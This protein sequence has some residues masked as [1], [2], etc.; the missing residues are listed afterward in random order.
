MDTNATL[1]L[2][3][4]IEV[5][6]KDFCDASDEIIEVGCG[7]NLRAFPDDTFGSEILLFFKCNLYSLILVLVIGIAIGVIFIIWRKRK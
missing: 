1:Q 6:Y 5:N 7:V 2:G 3:K 4:D